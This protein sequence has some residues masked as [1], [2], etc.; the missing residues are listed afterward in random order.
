[1]P[2]ESV[3]LAQVRHNLA[4]LRGFYAPATPYPDWAVTVA[5]YA[6]VHAVEAML[7]RRQL[8]SQSHRE[9]RQ[10]VRRMLPTL[11]ALYYRLDTFSRQ[12]RYEGFRPDPTL[13]QR[14][15]DHDLPTILHAL[16][17]TP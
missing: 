13:L 4:F 1:M 6:V 7:A 3:H 15:V 8:H 16:G 11:W 12:A 10:H 2:S 9:R 17:I 5:F 14:L